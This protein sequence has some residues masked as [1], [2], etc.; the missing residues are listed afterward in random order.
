MKTTEVILRRKVEKLGEIGDV[1]RVKPGFA[2]NYLL[3]QGLAY[4]ATEQ[5]KHRLEKERTRALEVEAHERASAEAAAAKVQ[6]VSL[7]FQVLAGEEGKLYGSVGAG[8]IVTRLG[9]LGFDLEKRQIGLEEPIRTLGAYTVPIKLHP[10]V[11]PE[12]KVWVIKQE[13]GES[14]A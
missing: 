4:L 2:R 14:P 6:D 10:D 5:N 13:E 3:P 8:D 12:I 9:E 11:Q 7:T 1:V